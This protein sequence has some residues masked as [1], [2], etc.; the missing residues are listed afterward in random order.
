MKNI[1]IFIVLGVVV[2]SCTQSKYACL[3][4]KFADSSNRSVSLKYNCK[5]FQKNDDRKKEVVRQLAI[6][7]GEE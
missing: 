5:N 6:V 3:D 1:L 2:S 4:S 7:T